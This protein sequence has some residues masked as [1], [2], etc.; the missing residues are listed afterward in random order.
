MTLE[1]V[2]ILRLNS[3]KSED[4]RIKKVE[5]ERGLIEPSLFWRKKANKR[6]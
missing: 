1:K 4:T 5:E 3:R 2:G 6:L